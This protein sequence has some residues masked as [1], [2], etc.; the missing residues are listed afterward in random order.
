MVMIKSASMNLV[1]V[2]VRFN[3]L[4]YCC[5]FPHIQYGHPPSQLPSPRFRKHI[6]SHF[7][8]IV[9]KMKIFDVFPFSSNRESVPASRQNY[10]IALLRGYNE[11][12]NSHVNRLLNPFSPVIGSSEGL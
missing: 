6:F 1:N 7:I 8:C 11:E 4:L 5:S 12:T 10:L 2:L 3:Q 9:L